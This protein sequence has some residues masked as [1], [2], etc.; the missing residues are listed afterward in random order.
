MFEH[1]A[2]LQDREKIW[3]PLA[4]WASGLQIISSIHLPLIK[5]LADVGAGT[6]IRRQTQTKF[7]FVLTNPCFQPND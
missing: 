2:Y 4:Q 1:F 3:K 7:F 6:E 5:L